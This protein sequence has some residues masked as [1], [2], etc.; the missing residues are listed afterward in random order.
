MVAKN[1][2]I[3][4]QG[5]IGFRKGL[6]ALSQNP[7]RRKFEIQRLKI[8]GTLSQMNPAAL[9][10]QIAAY[11]VRA[12]TVIEVCQIQDCDDIIVCMGLWEDILLIH[13]FQMQYTSHL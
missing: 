5:L 2:E 13:F 7:R 9:Q 6:Q 10:Q 1:L 11:F 4:W 8:I 3:D 12:T